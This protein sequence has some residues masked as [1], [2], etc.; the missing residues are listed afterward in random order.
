M[1]TKTL[2]FQ[3]PC[4]LSIKNRQL[5]ISLKA[6][7]ELV[8]RPAEDIGYVVL[9]HPQITFSMAVMQHFAANNTAVV[10]C[11]ADHHPASVMLHLETNS[12]QSQLYQAQAT[13]GTSLKKKLWKQTVKAKLRNQAAVLDASG[14]QGEPLRYIARKVKS[15][16]SSNCEARGARVYWPSLFGL[17]FRRQRFG[18]PPNH[19]LNYSYAIL[20]AATAKALCGSGLLPALGIHHKN[21]YNAFCLADDIMEPYR[22]YADML[23]AELHHS[24][25]HSEELTTAHK[26]EILGL[27]T[28]DV[29]IGGKIRPLTMALSET[30]AALSRCF[31]KEA[32]A[33]TYP[34]L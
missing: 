28:A 6:T 21:K 1:V 12:I 18:A 33:I 25:L 8:Q 17:A 34:E 20:R 29:H 15:G 27:L 11:G 19:M 3:N 14:Q 26:K 16:D 4:H 9:D 22:P 10:L 32:D 23:V 13:A 5:L 30:T 7:G 24:G 31:M 2:F